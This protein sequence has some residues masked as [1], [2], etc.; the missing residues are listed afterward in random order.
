MAL[1]R[2]SE[3]FIIS[4]SVSESAANTFTEQQVSVNLNPLDQ[5]VLLVL[6]A[7]I[8][9]FAPDV[10]TATNTA[11][12]LSIS[13]TSRTTVGGI[14]DSNVVASQR[15][16]VKSDGV[17]HVVFDRLLA[18]G[19]SSDMIDYISILATN[20]FFLQTQGVNNAGAKGGNARLWVVRAK[21]DSATYA[22]LVNSELLSE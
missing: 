15:I 8:D 3:P 19:P 17:N 12:T 13:T 20:N 5:E 16:D 21:A 10:V 18:A 11:Q 9:A 2:T 7:D 14:N 4:T 1:K 6:A 22:A